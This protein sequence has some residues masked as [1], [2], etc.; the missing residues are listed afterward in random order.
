MSHS[1]LDQPEKLSMGTTQLLFFAAGVILHVPDDFVLHGQVLPRLRDSIDD[2][3]SDPILKTTRVGETKTH[4]VLGK[5]AAAAET[6][7][8]EGVP[9][10]TLPGGLYIYCCHASMVGSSDRKMLL[11]R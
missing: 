8:S 7:L 4:K 2:I 5:I 3:E 10:K 6:T 11:W 9:R 1:P